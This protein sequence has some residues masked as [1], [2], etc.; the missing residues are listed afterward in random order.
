MKF[1]VVCLF[2]VHFCNGVSDK[3]PL[4]SLHDKLNGLKNGGVLDQLEEQLKDLLMKENVRK[5]EEEFN[6]L[7]VRYSG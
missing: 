2:L 5:E 6:F 4:E 1:V 7:Q 3:L